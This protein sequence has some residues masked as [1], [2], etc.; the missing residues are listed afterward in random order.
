MSLFHDN[1][2]PV[3][4]WDMIEFCLRDLLNHLEALQGLIEGPLLDEMKRGRK[5]SRLS[6]AHLDFVM[7]ALDNLTPDCIRLQLPESRNRIRGIRLDRLR[8]S[9]PYNYELVIQPSR[10][11]T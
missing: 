7:A 9:P 2:K 6:P 8:S 5:H 1:Q 3:S 11:T 10:F 4:L